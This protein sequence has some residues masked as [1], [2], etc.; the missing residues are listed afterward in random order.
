MEST[1]AKLRAINVSDK[2]EKKNGL[3]YLSWAWALD[4]LLLVDP[5]ASWEFQPIIPCGAT[6]LVSVSVTC[7]GKTNNWIL[8]VMDFKNKAIPNPDAFAINTAYMRCLAKCISSHGLGLYIYAGEDLPEAP[9]RSSDEIDAEANDLDTAMR[10][11]E[12]VDDLKVVWTKV[13]DF[14]KMYPEHTESLIATRNECK[15]KFK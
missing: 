9:R 7:F 8:P 12:S 10:A 3:S 1:Y 2:I 4:Q 11:S 13:S 5:A 14:L 15:S 6:A